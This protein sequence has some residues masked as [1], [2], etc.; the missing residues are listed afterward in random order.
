MA[1]S[2]GMGKVSD[3]FKIKRDLPITGIE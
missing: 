3:S 1:F 2:T